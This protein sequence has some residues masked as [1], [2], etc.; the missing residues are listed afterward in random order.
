MVCSH[1]RTAAGPTARSIGGCIG[2]RAQE[3]VLELTAGPTD[4]A[5]FVAAIRVS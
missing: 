5:V 3:R 4:K 1:A 2:S